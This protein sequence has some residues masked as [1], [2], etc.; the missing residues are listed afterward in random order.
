MASVHHLLDTSKQDLITNRYW[1]SRFKRHAV[2]LLPGDY[3]VAEADE[4]IVTVLGSCISACIRDR[5]LGLGGMNHF[6][7][8]VEKTE[9]FSRRHW[10]QDYDCPA[11]R[12]G[13]IAMEK[14]INEILAK[15]GRK[16]NMEA[17]IFGG[18]R[19]LDISSN[20]GDNNIS[21]AREYLDI[22]GIPI[23]NSDVGGTLARKLYFIAST[24]DVFL[25]K[26]E[27]MNNDTI[28]VRESSYL[29]ELK[30]DE[31]CGAVSFFD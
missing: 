7:L 26:I 22:E 18:A 3:Y 2:K 15:G 24:N 30:N 13:N 19:V 27:R 4:M 23:V 29:N 25:K 11:A 12:Y 9:H 20:V 14:L 16:E 8:P 31:I 5:K 10:V 6:M 1:D 21:F 28:A 17:K